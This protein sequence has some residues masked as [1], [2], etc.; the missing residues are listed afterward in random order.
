MASTRPKIPPRK[1]ELD[2]GFQINQELNDTDIYVV[3][4]SGKKKVGMK[5][6]I[7]KLHG[8]VTVKIRFINKDGRNVIH[9]K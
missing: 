8:V 1:Q 2:V 3:S 7:E 6:D 5:S 9:Y 4:I